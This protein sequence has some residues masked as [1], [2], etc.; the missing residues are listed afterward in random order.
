MNALIILWNE[1]RLGRGMWQS[2]QFL[3]DHFLSTQK[4]V[5]IKFWYPGR[6]GGGAVVMAKLIERSLP[7]QEDPGSKR[8]HRIVWNGWKV[9]VKSYLKMDFIVGLLVLIRRTNLTTKWKKFVRKAFHK[10]RF[11]CLVAFWPLEKYVVKINVKM[12]WLTF[13][14]CSVWPDLAIYWT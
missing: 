3:G 2:L 10:L 1:K 11:K 12:I 6:F 14:K 8:S 4:G 13:N 7:I 9:A 5:R